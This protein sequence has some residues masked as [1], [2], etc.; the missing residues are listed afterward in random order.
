[1]GLSQVL[2]VEIFPEADSSEELCGWKDQERKG[3][4]EDSDQ[5]N[6]LELASCSAVMERL[7]RAAKSAQMNIGTAKGAILGNSR[8]TNL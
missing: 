8:I 1:M 3:K 6:E 4:K 7:V 5:K 2:D